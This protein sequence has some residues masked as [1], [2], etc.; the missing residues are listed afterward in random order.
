MFKEPISCLG[1]NSLT[2]TKLR[3]SL[4]LLFLLWV[5]CAQGLNAQASIRSS[6]LTQS[7]SQQQSAEANNPQEVTTLSLEIPVQRELVGGQEHR[8]QITL[9]EGQYANVIVELRGI[10]VVVQLQEIGGKVIAS[11]DGEYRSQ[12]EQRVEMVAEAAGS[13]RLSVIASSKGASA[14][15]YEIRVTEIRTATKN[16]R[17][18]HEARKLDADGKRD[19]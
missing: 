11:F 3:L 10:D 7:S 15:Q 14:G 9:A 16:D 6:S 13:Y 8:Y 5:Q 4:L 17:L 1:P 19:F 18:L 12:G 2:R